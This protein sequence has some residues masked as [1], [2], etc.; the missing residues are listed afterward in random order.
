MPRKPQP[1][2]RPA[3]EPNDDDRG[4]ECPSCGCHHFY[5][6]YTRRRE[7]RIVRRRECR[8]CGRKILTVERAIG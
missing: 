7:D 3:P 6:V 2:P 5:V 1:P 4:L 8:H